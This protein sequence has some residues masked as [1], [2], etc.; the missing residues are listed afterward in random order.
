MN[1]IT[2]KMVTLLALAALFALS[3]GS[4]VTY[5]SIAP[6]AI[7]AES[8]EPT[9]FEGMW[10]SEQSGLSYTYQF[11]GN[12]F[13]IKLK[14]VDMDRPSAWQKGVFTYTDKTIL[15]ISTAGIDMSTAVAM[16]RP[17]AWLSTVGLAKNNG[18]VATTA[19]F[20]LNAEGLTLGKNLYRNVTGSLQ[21]L[22]GPEDFVYF[23]NENNWA[24]NSKANPYAFSIEQIDDAKLVKISNYLGVG[25]QNAAEERE[26]GVHKITFRQMRHEGNR[27]NEVYGHF[28]KNFLPGLYRFAV[29]TDEY[30]VFMPD[31]LPPVQPNHARVVII[32]TEFGKSETL[33]DYI[34]ASL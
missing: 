25:Y 26:P 3:L 32:R 17:Y 34:D 18:A 14:R 28:T 5:S 6:S 15:L 8:A 33:Y 9:P 27:T 16:D 31:N 1:K 10:Y 29:Y 21:Q 19:K 24:E 7:P 30:S 13:F 11:T 23:Y 4:C 20:V 22:P 12:T 2:G